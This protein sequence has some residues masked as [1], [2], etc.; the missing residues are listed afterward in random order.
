VQ[1]L[2]LVEMVVLVVAVVV[3]EALQQ[4]L[5]AL[6]IR[7]AYLLPKEIMVAA[8]LEMGLAQVRLVVVVERLLL[9]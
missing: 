9:A 1:H 3:I 8:V 6:G 5:V 4:F 7:Q 2:L